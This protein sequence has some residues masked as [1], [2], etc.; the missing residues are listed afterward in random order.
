MLHLHL[1]FEGILLPDQEEAI[2]LHLDLDLPTIRLLISG[3]I[4][5]TDDGA[6]ITSKDLK[7]GTLA[8]DV[9]IGRAAVDRLLREEGFDPAAV[10]EPFTDVDVPGEVL[11]YCS[12]QEWYDISEL[13]RCLSVRK[14]RLERMY[15]LPDLPAI[16]ACNEYRMV[17]ESVI[18]LESNGVDITYGVLDD[19]DGHL[20]TSLSTIGFS[21]RDGWTQEMQARIEADSEL[22]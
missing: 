17:W 16:I 2:A 13:F 3:M 14:E 19:D 21:L 12:L 9:T 10:Y 22:S 4:A 5:L 11:H 20:L 15:S 1:P 6:L 7:S 8:S 18:R